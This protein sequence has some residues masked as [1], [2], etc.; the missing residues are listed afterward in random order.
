MKYTR[1]HAF[2]VH[3]PY[4]TF[5]L[6]LGIKKRITKQIFYFQPR[7]EIEQK[8]FEVLKRQPLQLKIQRFLKFLPV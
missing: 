2:E 1:E 3:T 6:L 8:G 7:I 5:M 4:V